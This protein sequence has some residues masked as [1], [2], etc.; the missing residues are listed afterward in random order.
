MAG[1]LG[2]VRR[3]LALTICL[4]QSHGTGRPC[5]IDLAGPLRGWPSRLW[6]T[7]VVTVM[8]KGLPLRLE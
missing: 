5:P 8:A 3:L 6:L 1:H 4:C 2:R 7:M